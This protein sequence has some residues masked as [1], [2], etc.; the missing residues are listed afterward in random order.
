MGAREK[1]LQ[2]LDVCEVKHPYKTKTC[3]L[4]EVGP[5]CDKTF[6]LEGSRGKGTEQTRRL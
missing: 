5:E 3:K 4:R 1:T 2:K 6:K